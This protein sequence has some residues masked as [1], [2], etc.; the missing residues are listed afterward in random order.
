[1]GKSEATAVLLPSRSAAPPKAAWTASLVPGDYT[2]VEQWPVSSPVIKRHGESVMLLP[3]GGGDGAICARASH[4]HAA[5][6]ARPSHGARPALPRVT[7]ARSAATG[8]SRGDAPLGVARLQSLDVC[9]K[10][11]KV[12]TTRLRRDHDVIAT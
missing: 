10:Q 6:F 5:P 1:M 8:V 9:P 7:G 2:P 11:E 12:T 3:C 4:A